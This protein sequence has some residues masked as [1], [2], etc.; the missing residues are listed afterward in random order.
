MVKNSRS[1]DFVRIFVVLVSTELWTGTSYF[2][3]RL[4]IKQGKIRIKICET[5]RI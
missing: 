4:Q 3:L 2:N 1:Y 5:L